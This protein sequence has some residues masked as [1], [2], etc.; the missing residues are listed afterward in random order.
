MKVYLTR[1]LRKGADFVN[2]MLAAAGRFEGASRGLLVRTATRRRLMVYRRSNPREALMKAPY[3]IRGGYAST[4]LRFQGA[5]LPHVAVSLD[6]PNV[7]AAAYT[8]LPQVPLQE[9]YLSGEY[10]AVDHFTPVSFEAEM[11]GVCYR[12]LARRTS[13]AAAARNPGSPL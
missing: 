3:P 11:A 2:G 7:P 10:L 12:H 4:I 13:A 1:N 6:C 8:P 9:N 5:T